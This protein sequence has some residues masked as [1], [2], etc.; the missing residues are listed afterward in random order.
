VGTEG[1]PAEY[2]EEEGEQADASDPLQQVLPSRTTCP[3]GWNSHPLADS[4]SETQHNG[5]AVAYAPAALPHEPGVGGPSRLWRPLRRRGKTSS[6]V[7]GR[8]LRSAYL[9]HYPTGRLQIAAVLVDRGSSEVCLCAPEFFGDA[10]PCPAVTIAGVNSDS[11]L[12]HSVAKASAA[13]Q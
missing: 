11:V 2:W 13:G 12:R 10:Q 6:G 3:P 7:P 4:S 1:E 9:Y 8:L 5:H